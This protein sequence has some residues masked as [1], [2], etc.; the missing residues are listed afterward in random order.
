MRGVPPG[1]AGA[2]PAVNVV[3]VEMSDI[4]SGKGV[5]PSQVRKACGKV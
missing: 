5:I 3:E 2:A 4:C 1:A